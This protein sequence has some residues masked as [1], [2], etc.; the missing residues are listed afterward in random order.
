MSIMNRDWRQYFSREDLRKGTQYF[1]ENRVISFRETPVESGEYTAKVMGSTAYRVDISDDEDGVRVVC[2]CPQFSRAR[3]CKHVVAVLCR[4]EQYEE[5]KEASKAQ[6]QVELIEAFTARPENEYCYFDIGA[7]VSQYKVKEAEY[8]RVLDILE[9]ISRMKDIETCRCYTVANTDIAA[10]TLADWVLATVPQSVREQVEAVRHEK[11]YVKCRDIL[12]PRLIR[13]NRRD[14]NAM[15]ILQIAADIHETYGTRQCTD[16]ILSGE[17]IE[18]DNCY[19][20]SCIGNQT[21]GMGGRGGYNAYDFYYGNYTRSGNSSKGN[22]DNR[23]LC[24]HKLALLMIL[25]GVVRRYNPGNITSKSALMNLRNLRKQSTNAALNPETSEA[26]YRQPLIKLLPKVEAVRKGLLIS[27]RAGMDRMYVVKD[28]DNL[29]QAESD[30]CEMK[31]GTK[32]SIDFGKYCFDKDSE[33]LMQLVRKEIAAKQAR[34]EFLRDDYRAYDY[35]SSAKNNLRLLGDA[36]DSFFDIYKG[37]KL[38]FEKDETLYFRDGDLSLEFELKPLVNRNKTF[39]GV[40]LSGVIPELIKGGRHVYCQTED[41]LVR[42]SDAGAT[43]LETLGRD[44]EN[45]AFSWNIGRNDMSEFFYDILPELKKYAKIVIRNEELI[46]KYLPPECRWVFYV[47]SEDD[48]ATCRIEAYYGDRMFDGMDVC[49]PVKPFD[50]VRNRSRES[51]VYQKVSEIFPEQDCEKHVMTCGKKEELIYNLL[52]GELQKLMDIGEVQVSEAFK[53]LSL[54]R[55]TSV[56]VGVSLESGLLELSISSDDYSREEL[57]EMFNSYKRKKK[58]YRLTNGDFVKI[59]NDSMAELANII[60]GMHISQKDF[61]KDNIKLPKYRAMYVDKMLEA[62]SG[63]YAERDS[64]FK[65]LVRNFKTIDESDYEVPRIYAG[66]MRNYQMHGHKWLR[67]IED[68]GFGGIL[69]DDMGLGK[70]LQIISVLV[71]AMESGKRGTSLVICPASLVFNWQEEFRKFA[72]GLSVCTVTGAPEVRRDII[73]SASEY[74]VLISSYDLVKR[75]I[76]DY[77]GITFEYEIIDE[78]QFIKNHNTAAAKAVKV[79]KSQHRFAL[80]GTPIENRLSELWS[81]FDYLM[82]GFL[83]GY[84]QFRKEMETPITKNHDEEQ[85]TR[86]RRMVS[87]FILRRLKGDVL[88]DLP[89]KIEEVQYSRMEEEQKKLYE[90]EVIRLKSTVEKQDEEAFKKGKLELLAELTKIR[91]ICCDPSLLFE[92]Y[93]GGSAKLEAC[94]ELIASAIEGEHKM[95]VFSQFTSMLAILEKRLKDAQIPYYEITGATAKEERLNLVNRF[96]EDDTPVFLISLKAG[97]TGLNLTGADVVIHYDPWWN[98]AAQNQATDRA[99]RIG[100]NKVVSVYKLIAKD[101]IEEK[102]LKLQNDKQN[103]AD[104]ILRGEADSLPGMSREE[105]LQ[106]LGI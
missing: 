73:G 32:S 92:N 15:P 62:N 25:D 103:L 54:R 18:Q 29:T 99:H 85:T 38:P 2:S 58:Y 34:E 77:E 41:S 91:Q 11:E 56:K 104:A 5:E 63:L 6:E 66:I 60:D 84:D 17:M 26:V 70:T 20:H 23:I 55:S 48:D 51:E 67:T 46:R 53:R 9:T 72:P 45:R 13:V 87:P 47:D 8:C 71:A 40:T 39:H 44:L 95:L 83:Y 65:K 82:P 93:R 16:L 10:N 52:D 89:E 100:Q 81:I 80:T 96:N 88:K 75:D 31:V 12:Y 94:M 102:I 57:L 4:I 61:L 30:C 3:S 24:A 7:I 101:T 86:L 79:I 22:N 28:F 105:M 76:E 78:A 68:C 106:L 1:R 35:T 50:L 33:P 42:I 64:H 97:G 69:A 98:L 14:F 90:A 37:K 36:V 43:V 27:A 21:Y 74:D 59:D 49:D 19:I